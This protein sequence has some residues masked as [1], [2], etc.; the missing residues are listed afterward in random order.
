MNPLPH[1]PNM[2]LILCVNITHICSI[3]VKLRVRIFNVIQG[4]SPSLASVVSN[5]V[6]LYIPA[7]LF[8]KGFTE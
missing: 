3:C 1:E 4:S 7:C 6:I 2:E 8:R 5:T